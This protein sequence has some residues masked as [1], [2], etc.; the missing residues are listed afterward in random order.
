MALTLNLGNSACK[1]VLLRLF[2]LD[3]LQHVL[4]DGF[5]EGS[6]LVLLGLLFITDPRV[7]DG[8]ELRSKSNLLLENERIGLE[9]GSFL[10][11][12]C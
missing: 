9:F 6:L 10:K 3:R 4:D 12:W 11:G 1:D 5:R 8:F 7:Q 2:V